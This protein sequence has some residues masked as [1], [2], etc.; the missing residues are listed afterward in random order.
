M[1]HNHYRIPG[2]EDTVFSQES[3]LLEEN[4]HT[5]I[6]YERNNSEISE[7][8]AVQKLSALFEVIF[9][10]RSEKEIRRL[11]RTHDIDLVHVHNTLLRISPSVF[12]AA[13]KEQVPVVQTIHNFRMICP[14][15]LCYRDGKICTDCLSGGLACALL[16]RCY[17]NSFAETLLVTLSMRVNRLRGIYKK[18]HYIT[19]TEFNR[20]MLMK[21]GQI[22]LRQIDVKPNFTEE[23]GAVVP[24]EQRRK[25]I[26]FAGRLE[27]SKG[28]LFLLEVAAR[29]RD[30]GLLFVIYGKGE[31]EEEC[32][33]RIAQQQLDNVKLMGFADHEVILQ[34]MSYAY[35]FFLPTQWYEGFPM[36]LAEAMSRGTPC[37]VP[38]LGNA[39]DLIEEG[40]S[41]YH[42]VPN[43]VDS[44]AEAFSRNMNICDLVRQQYEEKYSRKKNYETL[45]HI[46]QKLIGEKE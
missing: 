20:Q 2:G 25:E 16:H 22:A 40:V 45:L 11:I 13:L 39:G 6:R 18:I 5:V 14:N 37:V 32:R 10:G 28:I 17:R 44:C 21:Q 23:S 29:M 19:L 15:G 38:R 24:F 43:D 12:D 9:S 35:A 30:S 1:V 33:K 7:M 41:G 46:Y 34:A 31:M 42:Y 3:K 27:E 4:G 26:L 36:S 8:N